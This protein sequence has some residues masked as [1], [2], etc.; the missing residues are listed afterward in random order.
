MI[1]KLTNIAGTAIYLCSRA[2]NYVCGHTVV[3]DGGQVAY[4]G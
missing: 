1:G 4:A 2:S 3:L